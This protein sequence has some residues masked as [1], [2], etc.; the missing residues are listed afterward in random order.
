MVVS[1]VRYLRYREYEEQRVIANDSM[2]G[3]LAGAKL[4]AHTLTLTEG[5]PHL[6]PQIFPNVPHIARFNLTVVSAK[7]ILDHAEDYLGTLAI[8]YALAIHEDLVMGMLQLANSVGLLSNNALGNIKSVTMHE[9]L[10]KLA[11][12]S[13]TP[14][15]L[16]VFHLVRL[17]RNAQ[18]HSGG[19]AGTSLVN[20]V[21]AAGPSVLALW[22]RITKQPFPT[23]AIGDRVALGLQDL[24][25]VLAITKRLAEEANVFMQQIYPRAGWADMVVEEWLPDRK[26]GLNPS[27]LV[28]KALGVARRHYNPLGLTDPEMTAAMQ[29]AGVIP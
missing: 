5:S 26:P 8:P 28:R 29:R 3:L 23:Y 10:E 9:E 1:L 18:I 4:A 13:F 2:M 24:I 27:Q 11:G 14:D 20:R 19:I 6:L 12:G 15:T 7:Y 25:G 21:A 22:V 16:E 17:A